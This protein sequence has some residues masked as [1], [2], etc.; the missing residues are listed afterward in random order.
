MV[1]DTLWPA[2]V[3]VAREAQRVFVQ[4]RNDKACPWSYID[5]ILITVLLWLFIANDPLHVSSSVSKFLR[6]TFPGLAKEPRLLYYLNIYIGTMIFKAVSLAIVIVLTKARGA[7]IFKTVLS[8]GNVPE[9]W[10]RTYLPLYTIACLVFRDISSLNPL[11]PNLPFDS[12]FPEAKIIGNIVV[13]FSVIVI[14]PIVE[15]IIFRGFLYPAFNRYM[16]I[17]PAVF[18]TAALFT[19]AHYPQV[20]DEPVF[21]LTIFS[22]GLMITY[23]RAATGSTLLAILLHHIYNLMYVAVGVANYVIL[24]Y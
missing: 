8:K 10:W 4:G 7:E 22:L 18:I 9:T 16:G 17:H 6:L 5:A 2:V 23:A 20:N 15:E 1:R 21:M 3:R 13:I 14:A 11:L 24:K 19:L 12:V